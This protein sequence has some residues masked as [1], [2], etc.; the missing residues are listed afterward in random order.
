MDAILV[1]AFLVTRLRHQ[2]GKSVSVSEEC[3]F[4][5]SPFLIICPYK[6]AFKLSWFLF[7]KV[8]ASLFSLFIE[9]VMV[10]S[11]KIAGNNK[12]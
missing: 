12:V 8:L 7:R 5:R 1:L 9:C 10:T 11:P 4:F 6:M 3:A 2:T